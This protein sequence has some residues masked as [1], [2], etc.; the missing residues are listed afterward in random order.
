MI[1]I[2]KSAILNLVTG[3]GV[4][5]VLATILKPTYS[6]T[7]S[8]TGLDAINPT[9]VVEV[10]IESGATV[11]TAPTEAV[12]EIS[13][14]GGYVSYNK[15]KTPSIIRILF[16]V[17]GLTGYSGEIP[18]IFNL[19]LESRAIAIGILDGM[20][21]TARRYDIETPDGVYQNYD[22]INYNFQNAAKSGV[23]LL[24]VEAVFQQINT[25]MEVE[26]LKPDQP[27]NST[28]ENDAKETKVSQTETFPI[29]KY[30]IKVSR[31]NVQAD[32]VD[33]EGQSE[34]LL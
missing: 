24:I 9:S 11:S 26:L 7:Y 14:A 13:Q 34:V 30:D 15:V 10:A 2:N 27:Q 23:T 32:S 18:N 31:E 29:P 3:G 20:I 5:S 28:P 33:I 22:L 6:I 8:D 1:S 19:T 21:E 25:T 16:T 17:E 4:L 12:S